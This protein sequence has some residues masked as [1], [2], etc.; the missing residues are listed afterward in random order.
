[1]SYPK[2]FIQFPS[3][4]HKEKWDPGELHLSGG[5]DYLVPFVHD[6][7]ED[8]DSEINT[9][10]ERDQVNVLESEQR[11][12][13]ISI[14]KYILTL[15]VMLLCVAALLVLTPETTECKPGTCCT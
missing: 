4:W 5:K 6:F 8:E 7:I 10:V 2:Q 12:K 11:S 13:K 14:G 15:M 9:S 1:M 3:D